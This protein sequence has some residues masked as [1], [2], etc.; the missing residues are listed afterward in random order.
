MKKLFIAKAVGGE[1]KIFTRITTM[2]GSKVDYEP[3]SLESM[4]KAKIMREPLGLYFLLGANIDQVGLAELLQSGEWFK[5]NVIL[6]A[7]Y[8]AAIQE[9]ECG[10]ADEMLGSLYALVPYKTIPGLFEKSLH[11]ESTEILNIADLPLLTDA[12]I[13]LLF[14][15]FHSELILRFLGVIVTQKLIQDL[16]ARRSALRLG[17]NCVYKV[18]ISKETPAGIFDE[19]DYKTLQQW[20]HKIIE[21]GF[22]PVIESK[23]FKNPKF[24]AYAK[25]IEGTI[26]NLL[27]GVLILE[28]PFFCTENS[29]LSMALDLHK[30]VRLFK[31]LLAKGSPV[32]TVWLRLNA[33]IDFMANKRF[34]K[35]CSE[36][37]LVELKSSVVK[38]NSSLIRMCLT[39][40]YISLALGE[41]YLEV[42]RYRRKNDDERY[43]PDLVFDEYL[44]AVTHTNDPGKPKALL[45]R[46]RYP[47]CKVVDPFDSVNAEQ[48]R[49]FFWASDDSTFDGNFNGIGNSDL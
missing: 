21:F 20:D 10:G 32:H 14:K 17:L 22:G 15:F 33:K 46:D 7:F 43:E 42:F 24:E 35:L 8:G 16:G 31:I 28:F 29:M 41:R 45:F 39:P 11:F 47:T 12:T 37:T 1:I 34:K 3:W 23:H 36:S 18:F 2:P 26:V 4:A 19:N 30:Y 27:G 38:I 48:A 40:P 9:I 44:S 5:F 13:M 49:K 25:S 6:L